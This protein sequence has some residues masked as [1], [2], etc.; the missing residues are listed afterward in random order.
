MSVNFTALFGHSFDQQELSNIEGFLNRS[1]V[2][3]NSFLPILDGYPTAGEWKWE[4]RYGISVADDIR[5]HGVARFF[6]PECFLGYLGRSLFSIRHLAKW[7]TFATDYEINSKLR[8]VCL[9]LAASLHS[10]C[11]IYLPDSGWILSNAHDFTYEDVKLSAVIDWLSVN[12]GPP[13]ESIQ[14]I[15]PN[16]FDPNCGNGY[17]IE[18]VSTAPV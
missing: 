11:V 16:D 10:P 12:C 5:Q 8:N 7:H 1:W 17:F 13:A 9:E 18:Q 6:G 15:Y 2:K 3:P 14:S 4:S